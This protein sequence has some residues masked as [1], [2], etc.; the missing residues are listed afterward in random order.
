MKYVMFQSS[1][2]AGSGYN[3]QAALHQTGQSQE[4][5]LDS[6]VDSIGYAVLAEAQLVRQA[7][8]KS[9]LA[10]RVLLLPG[11]EFW[12][13]SP[14]GHAHRA[15]TEPHPSERGPYP[16]TMREMVR[17]PLGGDQGM[18]ELYTSTIFAKPFLHRRG[19]GMAAL[20]VGLAITESGRTHKQIELNSQV[21]VPDNYNIQ[22]KVTLAKGGLVSV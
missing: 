16:R 6:Q 4:R 12:C 13:G 21:E 10:S 7:C 2:T 1:S 3:D 20:E 14:A 5:F 22:Y 8:A 18:V 15:A 9:S 11:Q 19:W 17:E